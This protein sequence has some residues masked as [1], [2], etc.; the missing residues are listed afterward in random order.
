MHGITGG[1]F[2]NTLRPRQI[3]QHFADIIK[4]IFLNENCYILIQISLRGP[5]DG[6]SALVYIMAWHWTGD[7]S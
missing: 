2:V 1:Q 3:E 6:K 5:I 7:K 4:S